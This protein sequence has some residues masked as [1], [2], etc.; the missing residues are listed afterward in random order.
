MVRLSLTKKNLL[1]KQRPKQM[2]KLRPRKPKRKTQ[3]VRRA[4][5]RKDLW[6]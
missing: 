6:G 2:L 1:R 4:Q 3:I 5:M